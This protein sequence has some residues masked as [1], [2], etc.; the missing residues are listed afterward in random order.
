M[1]E[2]IFVA[3]AFIGVCV[4]AVQEIKKQPKRDSEGISLQWNDTPASLTATCDSELAKIDNII[5]ELTNTPEDQRTFSS[6]VLKFE[7][8]T[9]AFSEAVDPLTFYKSVSP[10]KD[11]RKASDECSKKISKLFIDVYSRRDLYAVF[12][13]VFDAKDSVQNILDQKLLEEYE[14]DFFFSGMELSESDQKKLASL[15]RELVDLRSEFRTNLNDWSNP[16]LFSRDELEGLPESLIESLEKKNGK[17]VL[18]LNY[19][20]FYPAMKNVKSPSVRQ[21]MQTAFMTRGGKEN[22]ARLIKA[23]KI[24]DQKAK[25]LGYETHAHMRLSTKMA[26]SPEAVREFLDALRGGLTI[27]AKEELGELAELKKKELGLDG[28]AQIDPWDWRYYSNQLVKAKYDVDPLEVQTYFPMK[29]VL[30]GMFDIYQSLLGVKFVEVEDAPVWHE[31]VRK[32]AV[33]DPGLKTD[34]AYFYMDLFPRPGKYGHAAAFTLISGR[35]LP[36]GKYRRPTSSIVA[37]FTA[38]SQST[39]SLLMHSQVETMFHEFGHIMHQ[40]LTQAKYSYFSGTSVK[41]DFVEAPSQ[42][43]ENWVWRKNTLN[44]IAE[45]YE[46]GEPLPDELL[47][48]MLK[49][50][51]ATTGLFYLR[52]MFFA[53]LD[54]TYHTTQDFSDFDTSKIYHR[55]MKDI[56]MVGAPENTY[57]EASFGHLMGGYDAGYYGYLWSEVYAQDMFTKFDDKGLLNKQVGRDYRR[58]ILE[59]GGTKDP[60]QLIEGF[61][62]RKP[63]QDAFLKDIGI[64]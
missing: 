30:S 62:G 58:W 37:N 39:P 23:I 38:P 56:M 31:S 20:H 36:N 2:M 51:N 6:V 4:Y 52:Q 57:P 24:R 33:Y 43:L 55:L 14:E 9:A 64:N 42:M 50:K 12:K 34:V 11:L 47:E 45:H 54:L 1:R 29:K 32:F 15:T 63:N 46:T 48:K 28:E 17:Y 59:P 21:K 3:L 25:L 49:A 13:T 44:K 5:K 35:Q 7:R 18:T 61:L 40:I 16:Q 60:F 22:K 10:D 8:S 19:P 41:R 53:T 26:K 27:K